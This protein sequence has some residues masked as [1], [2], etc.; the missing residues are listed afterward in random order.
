MAEDLERLTL[1]LEARTK[2]FE[3]AL[4]RAQG[5]TTRRMAAMEQRARAMSRNVQAAMAGAF[6]SFGAAQIG[7]EAITLAADFEGA[8]I[9]VRVAASASADEMRAL[10]AAAREMGRSPFGVT[11]NEAANA[12]EILARNGL[13]VREILDGAAQ[14]SL[15]LAR[16]MGADLSA[17]A[18]LATDVMGQFKIS[19]KDM[20]GIVDQIAGAANAS[21]FTF[22]DFRYAIANAGGVAATAGLSFEDMMRALAGTASQ[23]AAG[24]DAGT[25]LRTFLLRLVP[26]S[27]EAGEE[28]KRLG[29]SFY[30]AQGNLKDMP[31]IAE[32][33]RTSLAGLSEEAK[34]NSLKVI[35]GDDA[36]RTAAAL[37]DQGAAGINRL[38]EAIGRVS[39][40][41]QAQARME[42][43]NGALLELRAAWEDFLLTAADQG[44]LEAA[45]AAV[46]RL[47]SAVQFLGE[48]FGTIYPWIERLATALAAVLVAR[49]L[50]FAAGRAIAMGATLISL[51][52]NIGATTAV[53][54]R[55]GIAMSALGGPLGFV[56]A[57]A[58]VTFLEFARSAKTASERLEDIEQ[59]AFEV[60]GA[61]EK[62][63]ELEGQLKTDREDLKRAS[64]AYAA[65][66]RDEGTAAQETA[67]RELEAIR[68]RVAGREALRA[69]LLDEAENKLFDAQQ[70]RDEMRDSVG[71]GARAL[72]GAQLDFLL[73][74]IKEEGSSATRAILQAEVDKIG[75][76]M[77]AGEDALRAYA[78]QVAREARAR[79]DMHPRQRE[80]SDSNT[81][82]EKA[83]EALERLEA[84]RDALANPLPVP[85][86]PA[87]TTP[88]RVLP[89][90][91]EGGSSGGET[92][93]QVLARMRAEL[94]A[95]G[96]EMAELDAVT[97]QALTASGA[98]GLE[99][100][101][102]A[103]YSTEARIRVAKAMEDARIPE[104]AT[105]TQAEEIRAAA[106]TLEEARIR[107]EAL[108]DGLRDRT[109]GLGEEIAAEA[110]A[111]EARA[112][113]EASLSAYTAALEGNR[114]ASARL[115]SAA[116]EG[117]EAHAQTTRALAEAKSR[118]D[119]L[120]E[121]EDELARAKANGVAI[122]E[123]QAAAVR[124]AAV[125]VV[126]AEAAVRQALEERR[127]AE[128]AAEAAK[129][130]DAGAETLRAYAAE[131]EARTAAA[132]RL[133]A[134]AQESDA[135]HA[136]EAQS[137]DE[138]RAAAEALTSAEEV[139]TAAK[140][141]GV[142][143]SDAQ[144]ESL[145]AAA[146]AAV[147]GEAA[148]RRAL[149]ERRKAEEAAAEAKRRDEAARS[150][151]DTMDRT[152]RE[153][154]RQKALETA[155]GESVSAYEE[156]AAAQELQ[157]KSDEALAAAEAAL[158]EAEKAGA[159]ASKDAAARFREAAQERVAAEDR[160]RKAIE[161]RQKQEDLDKRASEALEDA[162]RGVTAARER[163]ADIGM[164]P[165]TLRA[166]EAAR[167][168]DERVRRLEIPEGATAGGQDAASLRT[169]IQGEEAKRLAAEA[170]GEM[171]T[172]ALELLEAQ[173]SAE[174][175]INEKIRDTIGLQGALAALIRDRALA[176]GDTAAAAQA[177]AEAQRIVAEEVRQLELA[178]S[179]LAEI[180]EAGGTGLAGALESVVFKAKDARAAIS[181]LI[182]EVSKLAFQKAVTQ[183][184]GNFLGNIAGNL[185]SGGASSSVGNA[186]AGSLKLAEGGK[187]RGPGGP[188]DD[189][190]LARLSDGEYVV[191]AR[192]VRKHLP[193]LEAIN[194]H[195]ELPAFAAGGGVGRM[196]ALTLPSL[197]NVE[198]RAAAS[199][200]APGEVF[201]S[202]TRHA[203]TNNF[204]ISTPDVQGF[205]RSE[206]QIAAAMQRMAARGRRNL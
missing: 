186:V 93:E 175:A 178:K 156:R 113:G 187:V 140:A 205:R 74:A 16:A 6:A 81:A 103:I 43:F 118:A 110:K 206:T 63:R 92:P 78:L 51:A 68:Q 155:A 176:Q 36:I 85:E 99:A 143:I 201:A 196:P 120:K 28:M 37:A 47:T 141:A 7:R 189:Q 5:V 123:D 195:P 80:F 188:T 158:A 202:P 101:E 96:R 55:L 29:M 38:A 114:A 167:L 163:T 168:A 15:L 50:N 180:A 34:T 150:L 116:Q 106:A 182:L 146:V 204:Y 152:E 89:P 162:R 58:G 35:F 62:L 122:S 130:R 181:D 145:H 82:L 200:T 197:P 53:T 46:E 171:R 52:R 86:V 14:S 138:A 154:E 177:E 1:T 115:L 184:L 88:P 13:S 174:E 173:T 17:A 83:E 94:E 194:R 48:N 10:D 57:L 132:G 98:A 166:R 147:Q 128:E 124:S 119:A 125:A 129:R 44:G 19:A 127:K 33:L 31:A 198:A 191:R 90:K 20:G 2:E 27:K 49:G 169:T 153:L 107:T 144:A 131:I 21:K 111:L 137:I 75:E 159:A 97:R 30:D 121:A 133:L 160:T 42:G 9:R 45:T 139:L 40:Q 105:A 71:D 41:D 183:P 108:R 161:A 192:A 25:A 72:I 26:A 59:A 8:L 67:A 65:A 22:D 84:R 39:A 73:N 87:A 100:L 54:A 135:A 77:E 172:R 91:P 164:S 18:D 134:A 179:G 157:R 70:S 112:Q 190:I 148:V 102:A 3:N 170:E 151:A 76:T 32:T 165:E 126:E 203:T 136:A 95:V 11:A 185:F 24:A 117:E 61:Y 104:G 79:G 69:A 56:I 109:R 142:A 66:V 23:F 199:R 193:L 4:N 149:E 64:E 12:F 60:G